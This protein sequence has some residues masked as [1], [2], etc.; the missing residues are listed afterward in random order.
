MLISTL[1]PLEVEEARELRNG[2]TARGM[3]SRVGDKRRCEL[4]PALVQALLP[5]A[6]LRFG[7]GEKSFETAGTNWAE[8]ALAAIM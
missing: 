1:R 6:C 8:G 2:L 3:S 7:D 5:E 4:R